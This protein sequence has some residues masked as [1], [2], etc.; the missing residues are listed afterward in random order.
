MA[1]R[2]RLKVY[3]DESRQRLLV[4]VK[5]TWKFGVARISV[6]D[7]DGR[8][9]GRIFQ[10]RLRNRFV[11]ANHLDQP[12]A[13]LLS[14]KITYSNEWA[15]HS[16]MF[17]LILFLLFGLPGILLAFLPLKERD[18]TESFL[19]RVSSFEEKP[20]KGIGRITFNPAREDPYR[21]EFPDEA[22]QSVDRR[23]V[24]ALMGLMEW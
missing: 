19:Y 8:L 3:E 15:A 17:T 12:Q 6:I 18:Y 14:G 23:L 21:I 22:D 5:E 1:P 7:A 10:H 24:V 9:L 20:T 13:V 11:L 16:L 4:Q 2:R